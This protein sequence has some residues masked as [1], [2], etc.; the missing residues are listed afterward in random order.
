MN[1]RV[2]TIESTV[3]PIRT[4]DSPLPQV[5]PALVAAALG[6]EATGD[7]IPHAGPVTLYALRAELFRRRVSRGGRPG[8]AGTDQRPK[9]PLSDEDWAKLEELAATLGG[10]GSSPSAGQVASVLLSLA[11]ESVDRPVREKVV[12]RISA[13]T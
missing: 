2:R 5:D 1:E 6:A 3:R 9:I 7:K 10:P 8:I 12:E 4:T 11:I 13:K